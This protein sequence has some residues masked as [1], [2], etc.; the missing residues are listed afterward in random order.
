MGKW[1]T[2]DGRSPCGIDKTGL[3]ENVALVLMAHRLMRARRGGAQENRVGFSSVVLRCV[4][5]LGNF[6]CP[7]ARAR[8]IDDPMMLRSSFGR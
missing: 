2:H 8:N 7:H 3:N 1:L 6:F 4:C 5:P